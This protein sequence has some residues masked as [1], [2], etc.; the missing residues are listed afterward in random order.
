MFT[1]DVTVDDH[2]KIAQDSSCTLAHS[3]GTFCRV[4]DFR[5]GTTASAVGLSRVPQ[6]NKND[7]NC[8]RCDQAAP[9]ASFWLQQ[10][11]KKKKKLPRLLKSPSSGGAFFA[12]TVWL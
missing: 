9:C 6:K 3:Q 5:I 8:V 1:A 2:N 10:S 11:E 12:W 4:V 7:K